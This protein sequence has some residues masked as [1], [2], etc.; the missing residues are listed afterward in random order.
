ME[1]LTFLSVL[2]SN[3]KCAFCKEK[4][5]RVRYYPNRKKSQIYDGTRYVDSCPK[6]RKKWEK[7]VLKHKFHN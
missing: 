7:K 4:D 6:D 1:K 5:C 2:K 3:F